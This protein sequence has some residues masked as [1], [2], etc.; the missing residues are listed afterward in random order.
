MGFPGH[1]IFIHSDVVYRGTG[2]QKAGMVL[3]MFSYE[4]IFHDWAAD[5]FQ[6]LYDTGLV[7]PPEIQGYEVVFDTSAYCS[8]I[9]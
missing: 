6:Y 5:S 3:I 7:W 1:F 9:N 8:N 2:F 4:N